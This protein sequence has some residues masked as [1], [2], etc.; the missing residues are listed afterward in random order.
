MVLGIFNGSKKPASDDSLLSDFDFGDEDFNWD[1][2][3]DSQAPMFHANSEDELPPELRKAVVPP[4]VAAQPSTPAATKPAEPTVAKTTEPLVDQPSIR[5]ASGTETPAVAEAA[6]PLALPPL[7][8]DMDAAPLPPLLSTGLLGDLDLDLP[9][10]PSQPIVAA[11]PEVKVPVVKPPVVEIQAIGELS[12]LSLSIPSVLSATPTPSPTTSL[13]ERN[14][15]TQAV[16]PLGDEGNRFSDEDDDY[17]VQI[18]SAPTAAPE[19]NTFSVSRESIND[20]VPG[21]G[22]TSPNDSTAGSHPLSEPSVE[23]S[24]PP[25]PTLPPVD[26]AQLAAKASSA[27]VSSDTARPGAEPLPPPPA[28]PAPT[29]VTETPSC[30]R[31]TAG[32]VGRAA[33]DSAQLNAGPA[34]QPRHADCPASTAVAEH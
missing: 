13:S 32:S 12:D 9:V 25:P 31:T 28:T 8:G 19:A 30:C 22:V 23:L 20:L 4:G 6:D 10:P 24:L 1:Q 21:F 16:S 15:A 14:A 11:K 29:G 18:D 27:P 34:P 7:E 3:G 33:P 5:A 26:L 17:D 2:A